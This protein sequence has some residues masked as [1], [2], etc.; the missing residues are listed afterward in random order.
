[1][2]VCNYRQFTET[3]TENR[4]LPLQQSWTLNR[5]LGKSW[6]TRRKFANLLRKFPNFLGYLLRTF[7]HF[8]I[9]AYAYLLYFFVCINFKLTFSFA[10]NG[11]L[12][13]F[14]HPSQKIALYTFSYF[15]DCWNYCLQSFYTR[16]LTGFGLVKSAIY[17]YIRFYITLYGDINETLWRRCIKF[18]I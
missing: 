7:P 1:M 9:A 6:E 13:P 17:V 8:F 5:K 2:H 14:L 16:V 3:P 11:R 12:R 10:A 4:R 15:N 18:S